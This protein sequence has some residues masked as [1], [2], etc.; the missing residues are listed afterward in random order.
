M[1]LSSKMTLFY[2]GVAPLGFW[3]ACAYQYIEQ[4]DVGLT[5]F[6]IRLSLALLVTVLF[7]KVA[8]I[9]Y[10]ENQFQVTTFHGKLTF[11]REAFVGFRRYPPFKGQFIELFFES[12]TEICSFVSQVPD[13]TGAEVEIERFL[14][15]IRQV[16]L[17]SSP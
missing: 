7:W 17:S 8:S 1:K 3:L 15:Q 9:R 11:P 14:T 4:R 10:E 16:K 6:G 5:V 2:K 13:P 12:N